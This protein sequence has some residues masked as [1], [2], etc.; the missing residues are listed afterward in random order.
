[1]A[2]PKPNFGT[3]QPIKVSA[4]EFL[5]Q[6]KHVGAAEARRAHN[7]EDPGSKPGHANDV[8]FFIHF[9]IRLRAIV[10]PLSNCEVHMKKVRK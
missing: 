10:S 9:F 2:P 7:P 3:H 1:M 4:F 5:Y 8:H 6:I